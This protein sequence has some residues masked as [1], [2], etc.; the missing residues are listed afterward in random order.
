M[1]RS[2]IKLFLTAMAETQM[3]RTGA[4]MAQLYVL[5]IAWYLPDRTLVFSSRKVLSAQFDRFRVLL[6]DAGIQRVEPA[7]IEL[8]D[9]TENRA[10]VDLHWHYCDKNARAKHCSRVRYVLCRDGLAGKMQVEM[11]D[12]SVL[13]FPEFIADALPDHAHSH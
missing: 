7:H 4:E 1:T 13:A 9:V 10:F 5:P 3:R 12:Y 2:E 8:L 6:K 11:V